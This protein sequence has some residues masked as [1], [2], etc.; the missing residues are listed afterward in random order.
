[1]SG[2]GYRSEWWGGGGLRSLAKLMSTR[3]SQTRVTTAAFA[4]IVW[5]RTAVDVLLVSGRAG[6]GRE[7]GGKRRGVSLELG[8]APGGYTCQQVSV[9][10]L[11]QRQHLCW[12]MQ[13]SVG[14]RFFR[15]VGRCRC[16]Y[17]VGRG[18]CLC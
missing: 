10:H 2:T 12:S 13:L 11:S 5:F 1:M 4:L 14:T 17:S 18:R 8:V 7:K 9:R 3:V 15:R 16:F 6:P